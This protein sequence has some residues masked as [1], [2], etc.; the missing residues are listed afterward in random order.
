MPFHAGLG[1]AGHFCVGD[2]IRL[3]DGLGQGV[4]ARTKD[5]SDP[6]FVPRLAFDELGGSLIFLSGVIVHHVGFLPGTRPGSP[7]F[8]EWQTNKRM[9][10]LIRLFVPHF[11]GNRPC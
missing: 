7:A 11:F 5:Q 4:Q 8:N 2:A 10:L 1:K 6:W 9:S 3:L